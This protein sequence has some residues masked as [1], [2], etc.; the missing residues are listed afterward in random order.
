MLIIFNL[1][2]AVL[3]PLMLFSAIFFMVL[4]DLT[5]NADRVF[6]FHEGP[7]ATTKRAKEPN[8][9]RPSLLDINIFKPKIQHE[10]V[11]V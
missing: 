8:T 7:R 9:S 10:N 5:R 2:G 6:Y 1:F 4:Q 3:E 11:S